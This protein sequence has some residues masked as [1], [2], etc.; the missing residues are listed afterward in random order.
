MLFS[1][2]MTSYSVGILSELVACLYLS[3]QGFRILRRRYIT[4]KNTNRAEIDIIAKK[5]NLLIFVE[6]K[7]RK[8][9]ISGLD[10]VTQKQSL[11]LRQAA[12]TYIV[13]SRWVGDARFDI[14]VISG[15]KITWIKAAI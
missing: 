7:H 14:I 2:N 13:N 6:V 11:R 10:A 12:E 9:L 5:K 4:G 8:N 15:Y 3:L 1:L